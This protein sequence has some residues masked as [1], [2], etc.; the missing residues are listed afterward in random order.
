MKT[1]LIFAAIAAVATAA[2]SFSYPEQDSRHNTL[3]LLNIEALSRNE[4]HGGANS[5][6][7][8]TSESTTRYE[9]NPNT[10]EIIEFHLEF[11]TTVCEGEGSIPC[12]PGTE[13]RTIYH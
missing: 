12:T 8:K 3:A 11:E 1:K 2:G 5:K 6:D 7:V 10:G 4:V 9:K 13:I